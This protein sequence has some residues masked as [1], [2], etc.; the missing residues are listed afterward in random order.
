MQFF[1][2]FGSSRNQKQK[3]LEKEALKFKI[4]MDCSNQENFKRNNIVSC[5]QRKY[6]S[7]IIDKIVAFKGEIFQKLWLSCRGFYYCF[8]YFY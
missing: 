4:L 6:F 8:C 1:Y 2:K 7:Y 3:P 5:V